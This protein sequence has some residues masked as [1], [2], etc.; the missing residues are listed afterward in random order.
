MIKSDKIILL[1]YIVLGAS[2]FILTTN[3]LDGKIIS[4]LPEKTTDFETSSIIDVDRKTIF[5]L[6][7]N[8]EIYSNVLPRNIRL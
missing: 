2:F 3:D 6:M 5:N 8:I 1:F 4:V 7:T